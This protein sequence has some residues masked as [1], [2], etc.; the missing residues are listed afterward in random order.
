[1]TLK[2]QIQEVQEKH[3]EG[4]IEHEPG[5]FIQKVTNRYVYTLN[6]WHGT[7]IQRYTLDEFANML[8]YSAAI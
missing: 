8:R 5:M 3:P 7:K 6:T 4:E 2:E 1:M